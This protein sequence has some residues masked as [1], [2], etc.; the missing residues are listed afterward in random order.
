ML[1]RESLS[2]SL[3][4]FL[5]GV[6]VTSGPWLLTTAVLVLMRV[7]AVA[8]GVEEVTEAE[9]VVTVVY[10]IVIVLSAPIDIVLTRYSSDRVY[11]QR[12]EQIVAPLR[13]VLAGCLIVFTAVG[14]LAMSICEAPVE[15]VVPGAILATIV[16]GQWLLLSAAGGLSSPAII[17]RAFAIGAPVSCLAFL[18]FSRSGILG[19]AGYLYGFAAG[20]LVTLGLLL[21]GTLSVLPDGDETSESSFWSA[22]REYWLLAAAAFAFNAGLWVDKLIVLIAEG[23]YT[24]SQYAAL[25]AV[26]W[27]SVVPACAYLFV[28]VETR[29]YR[30]FHAFYH[31]LFGGASLVEL[32]VRAQQLR[33]QVWET[34]RGTAAVQAGITLL[35][36]MAGPTIV[37]A[38]HLHGAGDH[39]LSWLLVGAGLQVIAVA[40]TLLLYY[41]DY[42]SEAAAAAVA[43]LATNTLFTSLL[44]SDATLGA[45]Y[46]LACAIT[47]AVAIGLL[48]YRMPALLNRTFQSQPY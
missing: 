7:S 8:A 38:L 47:S 2:S 14:G 20:Q 40:T 3:G 35:A 28:S 27:L 23:G 42:R 10:A 1:E 39:T 45:G 17:L 19:A 32:D 18:L 33:S 4:A 26:A 34:L 37:D 46:P 31:A 11:E 43:Q 15:L 29:F 22:V 41:F 5:T 6:A 21:W 25:A 36:L 30:R 13:R 48:R 44:T 24:A 16:G 9:R 12:R